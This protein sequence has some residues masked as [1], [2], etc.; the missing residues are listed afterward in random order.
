MTATPN[1]INEAFVAL[2]KAYAGKLDDPYPL[3]AQHRAKGGVYQ[4]DLIAELGVPSMVAGRTGDRPVFCFLTHEVI[5]KALLDSETY[6]SDIYEEAFAGCMGEKVVL[7]LKGEEHRRFRNRLMQVMS[8]AALRK[9]TDNQFKPIIEQFVKDLAARGNKAELMADLILDFPI[10]VVYELFGLPSDDKEAMD[11][12]NTNALIM[13][14]GGMVDMSK[15][16]EAMERMQN[17]AVAGEALYQ[18][19][20]DAVEARVANNNTDGDDLIAILLRIEENGQHLT[21]HDIASF[22]RPTLAAAGETTS[23]ALGN[24]LAVLLERPAILDRVRNDRSLITAAM[25]EAM[26]YEGS[27]SIIPRITTKDVEVDGVHIPAGS[28]INLLVGSANRDPAVHE[29]PEVF[30]ID[31]KRAKQNLSFGFGPHMCQGMPLAKAEMECAVNALF[32]H[33]PNLRIDPDAGYE[34]IRGVQ[35]RSPTFLPVIWDDK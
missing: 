33:L 22:L 34:G 5:S 12:F 26:R 29:N 4:G 7:F 18:Q 13:V 2:S 1:K 6:S 8:P 23:R 28:G 31:I 21:P 15:P 16:E 11:S 20:V 30:D 14:L 17:A 27:V 9:L 32:D 10:R 19:I 35:F 25:N 3:Y 24:L